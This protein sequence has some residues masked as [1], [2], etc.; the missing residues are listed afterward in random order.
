MFPTELIDGRKSASGVLRYK[1]QLSPS[2]ETIS[3]TD[4]RM[5]RVWGSKLYRIQLSASNP[6]QQDTYT[7]EISEA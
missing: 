6:Q 5:S 7:F 2:V 4:P 1:P 3:I